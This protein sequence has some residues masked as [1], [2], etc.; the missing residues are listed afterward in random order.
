MLA[1]VHWR[2]QIL[3]SLSGRVPGIGGGVDESSPSTTLILFILVRVGTI[4]QSH[5]VI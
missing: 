1:E 3:G 4:E 5:L 2:G